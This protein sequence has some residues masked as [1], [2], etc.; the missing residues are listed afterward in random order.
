MEA[1]SWPHG[2]GR[3]LAEVVRERPL[4]HVCSGRAEWR[5]VTL[6]VPVTLDLY[7]PADVRAS[8]LSLPF[9]DD[10]FEAVFADPPWNGAYK[11]QVR[12]FM[13]EALRVARVVYVMSPWVFGAARARVTRAWL[14]QMPGVNDVV[15]VVRY[16]R[17]LAASGH[18]GILDLLC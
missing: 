10:S 16:E 8:W 2:V 13:D 11:A 15:A 7:E 5:D 1:F 3:F 9:G 17:A 4:L 14:R 18:S 12:E 6:P